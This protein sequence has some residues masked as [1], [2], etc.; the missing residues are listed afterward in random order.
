MAK[1]RYDVIV[2]GAGPGGSAAAIILAQMGWKVLLLDK[3][4]FPRDK[5]CGDFI[6]PRSQFILEMLGCKQALEQTRPNR[7]HKAA[8]YLDGKQITTGEIPRVE[9]LNNYGY[10]SPRLILDNIIF[11]RAREVG[12]ETIEECEVKNITLHTDGVVVE[13]QQDKTQCSFEGQLVIAADGSRS[14]AAKVLGENQTSRNAI[15]ALRAYFDEVEGDEQSADIF[16]DQ[17]YF[18]GYAWIFPMANRRANVGLGMVMDTYQRYNLNL[19]QC[20]MDW[21]EQDPFARARLGNARLDGRIVGWPLNTYNSRGG[22]YS[23]RVLLLGDAA[24]FIDP[25]NGEGIHTALESARMAAQ[26]AN[27]A[28]FTE[29]FSATFLARYEKRWRA[30]FDLDMRTS[31]LLV[32][33]IKNR[34]FNGIWLFVLKMIAQKA[35]AD[36]KYAET[37]GGILAGVVPTHHSLSPTIITKTLLNPPEAWLQNIGISLDQGVPGAVDSSLQLAQEALEAVA[38]IAQQPRHHLEWS[39]EVASKGLEVVGCLGKTYSDAFVTRTLNNFLR[40][41]IFSINRRVKG[42]PN[43]VNGNRVI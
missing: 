8:L 31:D 22:N 27:E 7:I 29:N 18:P 23:E 33:I 1:D 26:V 16:F 13:A 35:L 39:M 17:K 6:S 34:S 2:V 24:S 36:H 41:W 10:V 25:I 40:T 14:T 30:A 42:A 37:C 11:Q 5:V 4:R 28:L 32:T 43:V 21:I 12:A 15:L 38:L 19:R 9:T 3:A 20:L